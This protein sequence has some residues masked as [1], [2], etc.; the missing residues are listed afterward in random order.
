MKKCVMRKIKR[1]YQFWVKYKT[2][3]GV[4]STGPYWRGEYT[5]NGRQISVY[6][7]KELPDSLRFL[8]DGRFKRPGYEGYTWPGSKARGGD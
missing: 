2:K 5:E 8:L 4:K 1:V 6:I 7:G 3:N